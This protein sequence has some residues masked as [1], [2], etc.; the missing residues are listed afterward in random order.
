MPDE[1]AERPPLK[2]NDGTPLRPWKDNTALRRTLFELSEMVPLMLDCERVLGDEDCPIGFNCEFWGH[3]LK[4]NARDE[5]QARRIVGKL[6]RIWGKPKIEKNG[7]D[8][9]EAKWSFG[10]IRIEVSGYKPS[11]C[12][13]EEVLVDVPAEAERIEVHEAKPARKELRRVLVCDDVKEEPQVDA[14]VASTEEVP[15]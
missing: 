14:E 2:P 1:I 5:K 15:F 3:W 9:M 7:D 13:Y 8:A 12:R 10:H 4:F 6:W 11:T